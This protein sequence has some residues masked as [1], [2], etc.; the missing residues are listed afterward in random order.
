MKLVRYLEE[1]ELLKATKSKQN[2][3]S[4]I[5]VYEL[6][7][8]YK[9]EKKNISDT[10]S[11]TIYGANITKMWEISTALKDLERLLIPKVDNIEDNISDYFIKLD[12]NKYKITSV[13]ESG[14]TIERI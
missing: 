8:T 10:V 12:N 13:K 1:V 6:I 14:I 7:N 2:N 11:A 5:K 9:V 4:F 3:G